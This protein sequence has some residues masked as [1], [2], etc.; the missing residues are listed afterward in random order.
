MQDC[1]KRFPRCLGGNVAFSR[2]QACHERKLGC[3]LV[4]SR[5]KQATQRFIEVTQW[6][7]QF[8]SI[9]CGLCS[10]LSRCKDSSLLP[11]R[12]RERYL[13]VR[14]HQQQRADLR[15][16]PVLDHC[17]TAQPAPHHVMCYS[18][19]FSPSLMWD[20]CCNKTHDRALANE[21]RRPSYFLR[22]S[23]RKCLAI[24]DLSDKRE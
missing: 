15:D 7:S 18:Y 21:Q 17:A 14:T 20:D 1:V 10:E 19:Y 16:C 3:Q 11:W 6:P 13:L 9:L 23:K 12:L 5:P 24:L 8:S 2:A 4:Q 22:F